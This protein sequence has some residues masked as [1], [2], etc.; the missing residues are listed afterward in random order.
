MAIGMTSA[1]WHGHVEVYF[2]LDPPDTPRVRRV[3]F[4]LLAG[5]RASPGTTIMDQNG[6][7]EQDERD[8]MLFMVDHQLSRLQHLQE[9]VLEG[10]V[11]QELDYVADR[12]VR[13]AHVLQRRIL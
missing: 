7:E 2:H 1:E 9:V 3:V 10:Q 8:R 13:V 11:A 6:R 5:F 12:W 4:R